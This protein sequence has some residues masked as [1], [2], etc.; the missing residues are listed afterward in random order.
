MNQLIFLFIIVF[1]VPLLAHGTLDSNFTDNFPDFIAIK[2]KLCNKSLNSSSLRWENIHNC[3]AMV[4]QQKN[5][6][7]NGNANDGDSETHGK[8][9]LIFSQVVRIYYHS[10]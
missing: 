9:T 1:S 10:F 2:E 3:S 7:N 4:L 5:H 8:N 6:S